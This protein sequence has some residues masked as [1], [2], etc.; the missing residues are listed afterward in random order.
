MK[1]VKLKF[2]MSE[3]GQVADLIGTHGFITLLSYSIS[4][5]IFDESI[6]AHLA[7]PEEKEDTAL[8]KLGPWIV[9]EKTK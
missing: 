3:A 5:G 6:V 2:K 8:A 9:K 4:D 1:K 7:V